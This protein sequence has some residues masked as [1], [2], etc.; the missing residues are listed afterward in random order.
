M[1]NIPRASVALSCATDA[2]RKR[3]AHFQIIFLREQV[4]MNPTRS[5]IISGTF[6][7]E[8][9]QGFPVLLMR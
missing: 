8:A 7:L 5:I 3:S 1:L 9:L 6:P 4:Q 2:S